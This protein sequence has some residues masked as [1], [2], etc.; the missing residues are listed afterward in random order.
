MIYIV[1]HGQ[2]VW[3]LEGRKQGQKDSPLTLKGVRQAEN[4]AGILQT[5][6]SDIKKYSIVISPQWRCQQYASI[7]CDLLG[8]NFNQC[9]VD[10]NL[11][12]H[13]F[14]SWEGNTEE[15]IEQEFPGFLERRY[16]PENYWNFVVPKGESYELLYQR[17][18]KVI[19]K[20][21]NKKTIF[22]CHEMVSKVMRGRLLCLQS[23]E[24]LPLR[25]KQN[26]IYKYDKGTLKELSNE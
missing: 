7:I 2:T 5:E 3:N 24:I 12:E 22:I 19:D 8:V 6:I 9:I 13:S 18:S 17:V 21:Q 4:V 26:I 20:Y 11:R 15:Q 14:G 23:K 25:H 10:E 16:Q 1:R